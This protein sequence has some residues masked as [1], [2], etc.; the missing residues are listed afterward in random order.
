M[1]VLLASAAFA[2]LVLA[3]ACSSD[4]DDNASPPTAAP[5]PNI[6]ATVQAGVR[7]TVSAMPQATA[8]PET[9]SA[10]TLSQK[11]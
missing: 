7:A 6:E 4:D 3:A 8:I 10:G 1:K 9:L 2:I 5:A 11:Q